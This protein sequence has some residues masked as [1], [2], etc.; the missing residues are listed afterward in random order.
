MPYNFSTF[1]RHFCG[2][3]PST[4]C[5][6][7]PKSAARAGYKERTYGG[8]GLKLRLVLLP[9]E[10][11]SQPIKM[12]HARWSV[13]LLQVPGTSCSA[14]TFVFVWLTGALDEAAARQQAYPTFERLAEHSK[15]VHAL[16]I[17][18][19]RDAML[20]KLKQAE[21][22]AQISRWLSSAEEEAEP[23]EEL[24]YLK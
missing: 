6:H 10:E 14:G 23:P 22:A 5:R 15:A 19:E 16:P 21:R 13:P 20:K 24:A 1:E 11:T 4:V 2:S 12:F 17:G 7:W 18:R 3:G 9:H 8:H